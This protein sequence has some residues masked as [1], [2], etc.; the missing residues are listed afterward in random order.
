MPPIGDGL[1]ERALNLMGRHIWKRHQRNFDRLRELGCKN[2]LIDP[3]DLPFTISLLFED[4]GPT[5]RVLR[6]SSEGQ[7]IAIIR[8]PLKALMEMAEGKVDGDALFF[9]RDLEI[10]GDTEAVV[11]LRNAIDDADMDLIG[12][13]FS[14]LGPLAKPARKVGDSALSLADR[15]VSDFESLQ[16]AI[17]APVMPK[18]AAQA[19]QLDQMD[20]RIAGLEKA[21]RKKKKSGSI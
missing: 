12:E 17:L 21:L 20:E 16:R 5:M 15:A 9:S 1:L 8:G 7:D 14:V 13:F 6:Q 18:V 10:Q 3:V 2:F 19:E 4:R 11:A